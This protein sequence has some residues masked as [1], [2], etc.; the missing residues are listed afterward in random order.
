MRVYRLSKA[1]YAKDLHGIGAEKW[2]GRWNSQGL[3]MVY[4]SQSRALCT[5]EIAVHTPI[6][7]LPEDYVL[8]TLEIPGH[9]MFTLPLSGLPKDWKA[10]PP[11]LSTRLLGDQFIKNKKFLSM[12]V[13]SVIVQGEFN[14]LINPRHAR[15]KE[16]KIVSTEPFA[17]DARLFIR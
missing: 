16:V 6:G 12:K 9:S 8:V 10:I 13:P 14:F 1:V 4:T 7:I 3:P 2:G 17:F 5:A 15:M 11:A